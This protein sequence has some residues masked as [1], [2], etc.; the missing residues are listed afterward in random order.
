MDRIPVISGFVVSFG[1]YGGVLL[2]LQYPL[3]GCSDHDPDGWRL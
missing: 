1:G 2:S 3:Y